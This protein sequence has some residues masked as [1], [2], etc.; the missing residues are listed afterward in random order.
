MRIVFVGV[1]VRDWTA[2][3]GFTAWVYYGT[4]MTGGG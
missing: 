1:V 2:P 4:T 3:P